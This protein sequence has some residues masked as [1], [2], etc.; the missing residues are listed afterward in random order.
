[1]NKRQKDGASLRDHLEIVRRQTGKVP[2][3]LEPIGDI[4]EVI[5]YLWVWFMELSNRRDYGEAGAKPITWTDMQAWANLTKSDPS[6]WEI[7]VIEAIDR[8]FLTS[9]NEKG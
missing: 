6:V 8:S 3:Q 2:P 5:Y 9:C 4:P 1:L 7:K